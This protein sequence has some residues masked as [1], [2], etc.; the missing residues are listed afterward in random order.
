LDSSA[1]R[2]FVVLYLPEKAKRGVIFVPPFA[3]EMNKCRRQ[4]AQTARSL[5]RSGCAV[6]IVDLFGTGD[7][8][9][10]FSE[11]SWDSWK[12]DIIA[13][14]SWMESEVKAVDAIVAVRLGCALAAESLRE[15]DRSVSHTVFWQPVLS[16]QKF[17][18]QFLRLQV[19]ASMMGSGPQMTVDA[20]RRQ[21]EAGLSLEIAGYDLAPELWRSV[22]DIDLESSMTRRLGELNIVE[23]GRMR[24]DGLSMTGERLMR[25][26]REKRIKATGRRVPGDPIWSATEIVTNSC[27]EEATVAHLAQINE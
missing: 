2:I 27:L 21:L 5:A 20:L 26:A 1:G 15:S 24:N 3:E 18:A 8:D 17:I 11:A 23:I 14:I 22:E 13:A 6:L 10:E 12:S 4:A 16:G 7:S 9:G 25:A 19:A